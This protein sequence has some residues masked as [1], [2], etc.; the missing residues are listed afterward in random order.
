ARYAALC[1]EAEV[2]PIVKPEILMDGDH[3]LEACD[4]ATGR[5]LDA[6]FA[7]LRDQRDDLAGSLLKVNMV[8]PGAASPDQRPD[9]DVA[10]A[11]IA[12]IRAHVPTEVP[13]IVFLSGGMSHEQATSRLNE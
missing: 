2:V 13:G 10:E 6:L 7:E 12:C 9:G 1:Q 5:T 4:R 11:T 3:D 8:V